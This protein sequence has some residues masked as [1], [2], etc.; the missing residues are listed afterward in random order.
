MN[1]PQSPHILIGRGIQVGIITLWTKK[2]H[3]AKHLDKELYAVI[4]QLYSRDEGIS[5][6]IRSLL[7]NPCIRD[8][9]ITGVDMNK[10][11]QTLIALWD[12]GADKGQIIGAPGYV[13]DNLSKHIDIIRDNVKLHDLRRIKDYSL[14]QEYIK[15]IPSKKPWGEPIEVPLQIIKPPEQFPCG[16]SH[17][18]VCDNISLAHIDL[19]H[20]INRFGELYNVQVNINKR[21][22]NNHEHNEYCKYF[23]GSTPGT[24]GKYIHDNNRFERAINDMK[25][26]K[27]GAVIIDKKQQPPLSVIEFLERKKEVHLSC[28]ICA[29]DLEEFFLLSNSLFCLLKQ[30]AVKTNLTLGTITINIGLLKAKPKHL[31]DSLLSKA[32]VLKRK[33]DP[34]SNLIIRIRNNRI[35]VTQLSPEGKRLEEFS[36]ENAKELY[37]RLII[38]HRISSLSH[39][40]YAGYELA[41]AEQALKQGELYEQDE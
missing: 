30:A 22:D 4:S 26:K 40:A 14:L 38:E 37:K 23:L 3:V 10:C 32:N 34:N 7:L 41:R 27:F 17:S 9:I 11:A 36:G 25:Q 8:I 15:K 5:S 16:M 35:W 1:L 18:L 6:L 31:I 29:I 12:N 24:Y 13:D 39:A 20:R 21:G 33:G 19:G 28:F 2:E